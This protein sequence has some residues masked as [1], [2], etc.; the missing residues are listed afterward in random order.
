[1]STH[2][3]RTLTLTDRK[4]NIPPADSALVAITS[5]VYP[6]PQKLPFHTYPQWYS[7][8]TEASL[9]HLPPN[10]FK[11]TNPTQKALSSEATVGRAVT[12]PKQILIQSLAFLE[13]LIFLTTR[14][15]RQKYIRSD[16]LHNL[17]ATKLTVTIKI[18]DRKTVN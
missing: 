14:L 6:L 5:I 8:Q 13:N 18:K 11:Q 9:P 16:P 3:I 4:A 17:I 12:C 15:M 10:D 2:Y 1:M 7:P